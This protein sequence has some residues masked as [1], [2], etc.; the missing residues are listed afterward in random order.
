MNTSII[1][2]PFH[3][4]T[5]SAALV[6]GIP[7]VAL[8]PICENIGL[9]W[10]AQVQKIKRHAVLKSSMVMITTVAEDGKL[11]EMLMLPV[12]YLNGWLFGVDSNRVKPEIKNRVI[13][14]QEECFDVLA[15]HFMPKVE[16]KS[17]LVQITSPYITEAEA[18]QL[19]KSIATHCKSTG[20]ANFGQRY[21][22]IYD[23]FHITSYLKIPAG[24]L[25]EAARLAGVKL[26]A[27]KKPTLPTEPMTITFTQEE[28]EL[29]I[30]DAIK[31][32]QGY[33]VNESAPQSKSNRYLTGEEVAQLQYSID[34][35][36]KG[37]TYLYLAIQQ[38]IMVR[39]NVWSS[40]EIPAGCLIEAAHLLGIKLIPS[41]GYVAIEKSKLEEMQKQIGKF[42]A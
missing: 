28:V 14:Y 27:I 25:K 22:D 2:V 31:R 38:R 9:D 16:T 29:K 4:Q 37:E 13:E 15:N 10:S 11:R 7:H 19:S 24:K 21:K 32:V 5:L 36:C 8:K 33:L 18:H 1:A 34:T 23:Y 26:V 30:A 39:Y 42:L 40:S 35:H 6:N 12:K 3:N 20:V 41:I 17:T